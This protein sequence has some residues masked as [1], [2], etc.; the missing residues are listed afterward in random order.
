MLTEA[1]LKTSIPQLKKYSKSL[2]Y[3]HARADDLLGDTLLRAWVVRDQLQHNTH[4]Y[5]WLRSIMHSIFINSLKDRKK[6]SK[7]TE[8]EY[9]LYF[10]SPTRAN[11]EN[12][13]EAKEYLQ[14][15]ENTSYSKL[16]EI[17]GCCKA[18]AFNRHRSIKE[19]VYINLS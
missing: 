7:Q 9:A 19:D 14:I 3:N 4:A 16:A 12:V 5:R 11:Q 18:T 15:L 17:L 6:S 10:C 2:F 1:I 8:R 13:I